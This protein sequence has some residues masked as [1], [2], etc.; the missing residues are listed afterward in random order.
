MISTTYI[1]SINKRLVYVK[2][3]EKGD[4]SVGLVHGSVS[5]GEESWGLMEWLGDSLVAVNKRGKEED[6]TSNDL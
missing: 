4:K 5:S 6:P 1:S 2:K 3:Y